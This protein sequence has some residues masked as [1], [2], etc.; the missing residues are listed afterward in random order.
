MSVSTERRQERCH[1]N[2]SVAQPWTQQQLVK[3]LVAHVS[4][5]GDLVSAVQYSSQLFWYPVVMVSTSF[6]S[7]CWLR[8]RHIREDLHAGVVL[9]D[10]V[11]TLQGI[12][13]RTAKK[14]NVSQ[15]RVFVSVRRRNAT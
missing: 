7:D 1:V 4:Y 9:Y 15:D 3:F 2:S 6:G 11:P 14:C 5:V 8:K 10:G 12:D 13:E